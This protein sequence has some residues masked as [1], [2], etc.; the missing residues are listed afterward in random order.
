M[1]KI[2]AIVLAAGASTRMKKQKLLL[3]YNEKTIIESVI[4]N[5][6][7]VLKNNI[8]VVL[9][10]HREEIKKQISNLPIRFCVNENYTDGM[11]SSVICGFRALPKDAKAAFV[12]LGDQPHIPSDVT[13]RLTDEWQ[14]GKNEILIPTFNGRRG[15]PVLIN[16]K[17]KNEIEK[18]DT[19]KGLKELMVKYN[20]KIQETEFRNPDILRDIDTPEEYNREISK[21]IIQK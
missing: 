15:H 8:M 9:G 20:H 1:D 16:M 6:E 5:I 10:S 14:H 17:Y 13:K 4:H 19:N 3:P 2:W 11:L 12:F 18:L 7:P 21:I